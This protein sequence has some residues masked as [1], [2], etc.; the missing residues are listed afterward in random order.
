MRRSAEF[1]LPGAPPLVYNTHQAYLR[2][3]EETLREEVTVARSCGYT[4]AVKLVRGA[5]R[6]ACTQES[7]PPARC[8]R[9][10]LLIALDCS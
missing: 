8:H 4:L 2:G 3:A 9:S 6:G 7:K 10:S 5:Y 1:N